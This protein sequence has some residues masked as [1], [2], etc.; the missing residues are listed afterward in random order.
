MTRRVRRSNDDSSDHDNGLEDDEDRSGED[1]D[2]NGAEDDGDSDNREDPNDAHFDLDESSN[3]IDASAW[4]QHGK[5][6]G[7]VIEMWNPI[8]FIFEEG[9]ARSH[10]NPRVVESHQVTPK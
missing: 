2:D 10:P 8:S 5:L 9:I 1:P 6:I 4:R 3:L 7:R